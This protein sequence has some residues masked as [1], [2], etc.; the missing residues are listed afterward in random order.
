MMDQIVSILKNYY[1]EIQIALFFSFFSPNA[2]G[3]ILQAYVK[4]YP[5]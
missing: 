4:Q 5:L 3:V 1:Y 2:E